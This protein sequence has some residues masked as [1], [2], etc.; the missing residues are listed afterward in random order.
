LQ[1]KIIFASRFFFLLL[2]TAAHSA[3]YLF[4]VRL[5]FAVLGVTGMGQEKLHQSIKSGT[6]QYPNGG[7]MIRALERNFQTR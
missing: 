5:L 2:R 7:K 1:E 3:N 6:S 4:S